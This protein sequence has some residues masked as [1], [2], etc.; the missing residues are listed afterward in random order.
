M[1]YAIFFSVINRVGLPNLFSQ[2][3][4]FANVTSEPIFNWNLTFLLS[5]PTFHFYFWVSLSNQLYLKKEFAAFF[6]VFRQCVCLWP[7]GPQFEHSFLLNGHCLIYFTGIF[8]FMLFF[9]LTRFILDLLHS[10]IFT[11]SYRR[12]SIYLLSSTVVYWRPT[13]AGCQN[14]KYTSVNNRCIQS[15]NIRI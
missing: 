8:F 11:V 9:F 2:I 4:S 12:F 14:R 3:C 1:Q 6:F 5:M 15:M 13:R 10:L 7:F